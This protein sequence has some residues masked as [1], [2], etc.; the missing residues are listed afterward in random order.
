MTGRVYPPLAARFAA[1]VD[2]TPGLGPQGDCWVWTG[3]VDTGGYGQMRRDGKTVRVH[4][5]AW[6]IV[7]GPVP[8]M[9]GHHGVCVCHMCDN[10]RCVNPAHLFLGAHADNMYDAKS[11]MKFSR[12]TGETSPRSKLTDSVVRAIRRDA[13]SL[14]LIAAQYGISQTTASGVRR[15]QLWTHVTEEELTK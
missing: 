15:R 9:P 1:R 12:P 13:R 8:V 7:N 6:E 11:K 2:K 14:K 5:V 4:R 10:R 3:S